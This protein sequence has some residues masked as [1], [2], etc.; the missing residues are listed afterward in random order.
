M[1]AEEFLNE[2]C[3]PNDWDGITDQLNDVLWTSNVIQYMEDYSAMNEMKNKSFLLEKCIE[4][5]MNGNVLDEY[6][7]PEIDSHQ[8]NINKDKLREALKTIILP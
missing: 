4:A 7:L 6:Y 3:K 2:R 1:N 5:V 8:N